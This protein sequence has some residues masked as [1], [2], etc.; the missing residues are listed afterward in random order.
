MQSRNSHIGMT[1]SMC[2]VQ[3]SSF[4]RIGSECTVIFIGFN[5]RAEK[6]HVSRVSSLH[7]RDL[8]GSE[9]GEGRVTVTEE[10]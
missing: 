9:A 7:E 5:Y 3:L 6:N 1:S 8:Q 10:V 2:P 4:Q